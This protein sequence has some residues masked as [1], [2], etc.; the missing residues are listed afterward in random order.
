MKTTHRA[1]IAVIALVLVAVLATWCWGATRPLIL[2]SSQ[3]IYGNQ[4]VNG[5]ATVNGGLTTTGAAQS[6]TLNVTSTSTLSGAMTAPVCATATNTTTTISAATC[7]TYYGK[8]VFLTN[9]GAVTI[10]LP[11]NKTGTVVAAGTWMR[12]IRTGDEALAV[13]T[14]TADTLVTVNN[15]AADG[16]NFANTADIGACLFVVSNG[17]NWVAIN[18]SSQTMT[19]VDS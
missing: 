18:Q 8:T 16:V 1:L 7:A 10:T 9:A 4:T 3:I 13:N 14:T 2:R 6:A 19:V 15:A 11:E 17:T 12:F 5:N